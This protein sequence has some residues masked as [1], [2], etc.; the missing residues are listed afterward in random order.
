MEIFVDLSEITESQVTQDKVTP[1]SVN[2]NLSDLVVNSQ[3]QPTLTVSQTELKTESEINTELENSVA[4]INLLKSLRDLNNVPVETSKVIEKALASTNK[5]ASAKLIDPLN[6]LTKTLTDK[7][8]GPEI[9]LGSETPSADLDVTST[10]FLQISDI[11]SD[12]TEVTRLMDLLNPPKV[13]DPV[14]PPVK[15]GSVLADS[16][17]SNLAAELVGNTSE[18]LIDKVASSITPSLD[19]I[20]NQ[21]DNAQEIQRDQQSQQNSALLDTVSNFSNATLN[22]NQTIIQGSNLQDPVKGE[23]KMVSELVKPDL[24]GQ[25]LSAIQKMADNTQS[26]TDVTTTVNSMSQ[27]NNSVPDVAQPTAQGQVATT[28]PEDGRSTIINSQ[29]SDTS[30]VYLMQMLNLMKSGQIKVKIN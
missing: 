13:S 18:N 17:T 27:I 30:A 20:N 24:S 6:N 7:A 29:G 3:P 28:T 19:V 9:S 14:T 26:L 8:T 10:K 1:I 22:Q 5:E 16:V 4:L 11:Q 25:T 12:L 2:L 21:L 23:L 15:P